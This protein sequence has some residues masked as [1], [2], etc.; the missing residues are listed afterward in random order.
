MLKQVV[1]VRMDLKL[2]PGKLA[3]QVAHGAVESAL[4]TDRKTIEQWLSHGAKKV[5][6]KVQNESELKE[7]QK[8]LAHEK[9]RCALIT[10]AGHTE[11]PAG[12]VTCLG[13]GPDLEEKI[14][15]IT[16]QLKML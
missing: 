3:A 2:S 4:K 7:Y 5:V 1:L 10:D 14:D 8:K 6:L 11:I 13:V 9:I 16:G 12:T 15:N